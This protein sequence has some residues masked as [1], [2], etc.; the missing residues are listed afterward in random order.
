MLELK[1][2]ATGLKSLFAKKSCLE[3]NTI[4]Q[5]KKNDQD[6]L[7]RNTI[8]DF[9][10]LLEINCSHL[11]RLFICLA[12]LLLCTIHAELSSLLPC[13]SVCIDVYFHC[14]RHYNRIGLPWPQ[15]LDCTNF[16]S[17]P[18][19]CV[20]T[21]S[22]KSTQ[23]SST[24]SSPTSLQPSTSLSL[25]TTGNDTGT[26]TST[27]ASYATLT[28]SPTSLQPPTTSPSSKTTDD[29]DTSSSAHFNF[30]ALVEF[31]PKFVS[32]SKYIFSLVSFSVSLPLFLFIGYGLVMIRGW[33][34]RGHR[35]T[36]T[37]QQHL[38]DIPLRE[39]LG[40]LPPIPNMTSD[41][42]YDSWVD[43]TDT[44]DI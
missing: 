27:S 19:L 39:R 29:T 16:P 10:P 36:L 6:F 12:H 23:V 21:S 30:F 24:F 15:H 38:R 7:A 17:P 2:F 26:P 5:W 42:H 37:E 18:S 33:G 1:A 14:I 3:L 40:P 41:R 35:V 43:K 32:Y 11:T 31:V 44:A 8:N 9:R 13:R 34:K 28:A 20:L 22:P 4:L 25:K